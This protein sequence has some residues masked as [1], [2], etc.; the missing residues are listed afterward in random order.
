MSESVGATAAQPVGRR[1]RKKAATRKALADAALRLF[2]EHGYDAVSIRD[3]AEAAD[4]STTTVFKHFPGK[5]ALVFDQDED[6]EAALVTAVRDRPDGRSVPAALRAYMRGRIHSMAEPEIARFL[7]LID[8]TPALRTYGHHMWMRHE[9]ALAHAIAAETGTREDDPACAALAH[10][11][12]EA[13]ALARR[14][15]DPAQALDAAF[16]LLEHGWPGAS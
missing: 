1:E 11:A 8:G 13:L 14:Q 4:V 2:L 15:A 10:F 7:R 12:L 16:D 5:E 9:T 6:I 3:I